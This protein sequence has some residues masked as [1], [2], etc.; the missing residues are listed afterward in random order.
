MIFHVVATV[1]EVF[2]T[3]SQIWSWKYPWVENS[4][5]ILWNVPLFTWFMYSAV[6]SYIIRA[7]QFLKLKYTQYPKQNSVA[8]LSI[9]IYINFF[10]HH[11]I[12][13]LRYILIIISIILF[14]KTYITFKVYKKVRKIHFL[15]SAFLTTIFIWVAENIS[16]FYKIWLY[17]NQEISWQIVSL[18]KLTS[19]YLLLMV[20]FTIITTINRKNFIMK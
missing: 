10:S 19:W 17:P 13:D 14:F 12:L 11:Y 15:T 9:F 18:S 1:M 20:S 8:L 6:G 7:S 2:K 16:T 5:F 4:I 3:S